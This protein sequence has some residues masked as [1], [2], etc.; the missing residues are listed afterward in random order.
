M[1]N[2]QFNKILDCVKCGINIPVALRRLY[3]IKPNRPKLSKDQ[4]KELVITLFLFYK[5]REE[6]YIIDFDTIEY[7]NSPIIYL[8]PNQE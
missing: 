8:K 3:G 2:Q 7:L 5:D 4:Y 6:E 1:T